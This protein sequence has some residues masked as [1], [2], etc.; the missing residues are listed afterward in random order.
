[1]TMKK[2]GFLFV[3]IAFFMGLYDLQAQLNTPALSPLAKIEQTVGITTIRVEYSRPSKRGRTVFP[4]VV[5]DRQIWRVGA[6]KNT[7]IH[8]DKD[9][10]FEER[11]LLPAGSYGIYAIPER[12]SWT[13]FFYKET[14]HRGVPEKWDDKLV[15]LKTRAKIREARSIVETFTISFDN[16]TLNSGELVFSWDRYAVALPFK[17]TDQREIE[18]GIRKTLAAKPTAA[19]YYQAADY[20]VNS[21]GDMKQALEWIDLAIK[22]NDKKVPYWYWQRKAQIQANLEDYRSAVETAKQGLEAA[23]QQKDEHYIRTFKQAIEEWNR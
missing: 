9:L 3:C 15:A 18:Q 23:E 12:D 21:K 1:M 11:Q 4:D 5:P 13:I 7:V 22:K 10:L 19:N 2:T 6:N 17:V 14:E 20:Y 8:L 16:L